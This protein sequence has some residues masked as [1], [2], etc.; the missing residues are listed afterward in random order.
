MRRVER[1]N[2]PT[3]QRQPSTASG[4][5]SENAC[6]PTHEQL[7]LAA[8]LEECFTHRNGKPAIKLKNEAVRLAEA[9]RNTSPSL[10]LQVYKNLAC[11]FYMERRY[12]QSLEFQEHRLDLAREV[13]DRMEEA[14]AVGGVGL[15]Q[16]YLGQYADALK[17]HQMHRE[18]ARTIEDREEEGKASAN[19]GAWYDWMEMHDRAI[20]FHEQDLEISREIQ[21]RAGEERALE[22]LSKDY[23]AIAQY[24]K[25]IEMHE[26]R[27]AV[28]RHSGDA[29]AEATWSGNLGIVYGSLGQWAQAIKLLE[30]WRVMARKN[31]NLE[32]Q[33]SACAKLGDCYYALGEY[34]RA[35]E[36]HK[37]A[38]DI[39]SKAGDPVRY[40]RACL[41]IGDAY[42][43]LGQWKKAVSL[44]EKHRIAARDS[45][46]R[47]GEGR[48]CGAIGRASISLGDY[49]KAIKLLEHARLISR[50]VGNRAGEGRVCTDLGEALQKNDDAAGAA[51]VL[52]QGIALF[53]SIESDIAAH[54]DWRIS[55]FEQQQKA[56]RLLQTALL[57]LGHDAW[58]LAVCE[59]AKAR[60]LSHLLGAG[61]DS[62]QGPKPNAS[63]NSVLTRADA[64]RAWEESW[65][66]TQTL[67]RAEGQSTCV[68][69]YSLLPEEL[70]IGVLSGN[71]D[72]LCC[73]TLPVSVLAGRFVAQPISVG[74]RS[75]ADTVRGE[76]E[77]SGLSIKDS[78]SRAKSAG[79]SPYCSNGHAVEPREVGQACSCDLCDE[80]GIKCLLLTRGA[81]ETYYWCE[82]CNVDM[83]D[84]WCQ[85][86]AENASEAQDGS[87]LDSVDSLGRESGETQPEE[88]SRSSSSQCIDQTANTAQQRGAGS[89]TADRM[90][91]FQV[92][93]AIPDFDG[94][95]EVSFPPV[96][97]LFC[98]CCLAIM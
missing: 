88:S 81:A 19:I 95:Q 45:N 36:C 30:R 20:D 43:M 26:Q 85:R 91:G 24:G 93:L 84:R 75:T 4:M 22:N 89:Q 57:E 72:L 21:S 67:A 37:K 82:T 58:A 51:L 5:S 70:A 71:G 78:L 54:D 13:G 77:H 86:R 34:D 18:I 52:A 83:C 2:P 59:Q 28:A 10:S 60:A 38:A 3:R 39:S 76:R 53:Q 65:K 55:L 50:G 6:L 73:K 23:F 7:D 46:D 47:D 98:R 97:R 63:M 44:Y 80:Q 62:D 64:E 56:Y 15:A 41:G 11:C 94:Y 48:A 66:A 96:W 17:S 31:G 8:T 79:V 40:G 33:C 35:I 87:A 12:I 9:V 74:S 25:A 27:L 49:D 69:E 92:L 42:F 14:K 68:L 16:C 29:S 90:R 1:G 32:G 61:A